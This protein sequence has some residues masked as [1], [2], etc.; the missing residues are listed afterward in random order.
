ML[1]LAVC[2]TTS[3]P[4]VLRNYLIALA[5]ADLGHIYATYAAMG[6]ESFVD[7]AGWG[8]VAWGNIGASGFLFVNR[9]MYLLGW[10]GEPKGKERAPSS[11]WKKGGGKKGE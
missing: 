2:Y 11:A 1:G 3:E 7:V 5:V 8:A 9:V 10:F 4:R 6:W